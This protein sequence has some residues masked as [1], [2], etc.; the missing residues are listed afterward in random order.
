[1]KYATNF[2]DVRIWERDK[3][4][5]TSAVHTIN[6]NDQVTISN[7][8]TPSLGGYDDP[9]GDGKDTNVTFNYTLT[10][11]DG[12][13]GFRVRL[14][15]KFPPSAGSWSTAG[16]IEDRTNPG[17]YTFTWNPSDEITGEQSG[18]VKIRLRV[19]E[20]DGST[21][22]YSNETGT[23]FLDMWDDSINH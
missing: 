16:E 8:A 9:D 4:G 11:V 6:F 2:G 18:D 23:F 7:P 10:D 3:A 19:R 15:Y 13:Q 14:E 12:G 1:M 20:L 5:N 22:D 17:S 21:W